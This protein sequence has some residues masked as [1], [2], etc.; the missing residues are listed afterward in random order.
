MSYIDI[1]V[2]S[3]AYFRHDD[4]ERWDAEPNSVDA[5]N[6]ARPRFI[7]KASRGVKLAPGQLWWPSSQIF[8]DPTL[9][10]DVASAPIPFGYAVDYTGASGYPYRIRGYALDSGGAGVGGAVM[11]LFRT[12]DDTYL[13]Q[14]VSVGPSGQYDLGVDTNSVQ[15]YIVA[16]RTGPD[17][18]GT[19]VNTLTGASD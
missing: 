4:R 3:T 1:Q 10:E 6:F 7:A 11:Q 2:L 8:A 18:E 15:H 12:S 13:G 17:I 14:A 9:G 19:T 16:Y 5:L